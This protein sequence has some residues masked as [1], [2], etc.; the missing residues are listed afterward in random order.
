MTRLFIGTFFP[1]RAYDNMKA[2]VA[3]SFFIQA[4]NIFCLLFYSIRVADN[5]GFDMKMVFFFFMSFLFFSSLKTPFSMVGGKKY[6]WALALY[7][8]LILL[9]KATICFLYRIFCRCFS[10]QHLKFFFSFSILCVLRKICDKNVMKMLLF[11]FFV[12]FEALFLRFLSISPL[13]KCKKWF[14][15]FNGKTAFC[16]YSVKCVLSYYN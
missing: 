9:K 3:T 7:Q 15:F 5:F 1:G 2:I 16:N 4:K 11:F 12:L 14:F 6:V 8:V 10:I 13:R